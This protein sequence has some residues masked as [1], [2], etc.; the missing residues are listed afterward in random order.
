MQPSFID[1]GTTDTSVWLAYSRS[2]SHPNCH[3]N[4]FVGE[5]QTNCCYWWRV[6]PIPACGAVTALSL[7]FS[8]G[9]VHAD[10]KSVK[11]VITTLLSHALWMCLVASLGSVLG[12]WVFHTESATRHCK[13][14]GTTQWFRQN[15]FVE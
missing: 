12:V 15:S 13:V 11:A 8:T 1:L 9:M 2:K 7:A 10:S 6:Q 4:G 14:I 3:S 5:T